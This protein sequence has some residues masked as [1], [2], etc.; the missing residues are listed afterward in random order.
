MKFEEFKKNVEQWAEVRGIYEQSTEAHQQAKALEE[1]GELLT[2]ENDEQRMD[3][4]GDIAVCIVNA[5]YFR[6]DIVIKNHPETG[7]SVFDNVISPDGTYAGIASRLLYGLYVESIIEL[8]EVSVFFRLK[9]EE[10]LE[11]AWNEI[12]DR[13]GMMVDGKFVKWD[14]LSDEQRDEFNRRVNC[15]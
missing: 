5:A 8:I 6:S 4:I 9:F 11:K 3:A 2:A 13:K 15:G 7:K 12:K 1:I 14:N 10:C